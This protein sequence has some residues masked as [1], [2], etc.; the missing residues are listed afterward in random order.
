MSTRH[1]DS[2]FEPRSVAV[3]GA[4]DRPGSV[5]A[6]VWAN[7]AGG[8]FDGPVW[9]VNPR[10]PKLGTH[11]VYARASQLPEAPDL[12]VIC[13]PPA[14]VA[15]LVAELGARGTG[16]AIVM[17]AALDARQRRAL[18]DAARPH[19][20]R[21]LGPNCLGL[22]NPRLKLNASFA[23]V[24]AAPGSLAFVSQSGALV[25]ALLDWAAARG[26]G[27]SLFASIGDR[28]DVDFGDMI[29]YLASD[30]HT[31]AILL[32]VEAVESARKFMSAARAAARNKPVLIV[33]AGRTPAGQR[34]A[35]SHTGALAS[36][37]LVFDAAIRRA[38]MLRVGTLQ[39]LFTAAEMLS[40]HRGPARG[41]PA[42]PHERLTVLTNGGGAGV[43]A[44]DA[45]QAAELALAEPSAAVL[46]ALTQALPAG[47]SHANPVDIVGDAPVARYVA[48]IEAL[49]TDA[50]PGTLLFIHAPTAIVPSADVARAVVPLLQRSPLQPMTCWLGGDAVREARALS[51]AAGLPTYDTPEEAVRAFAMLQTYRRNQ[52]LLLQTPPAAPAEPLWHAAQVHAPIEAALAD[53]REWLTEPE[54]KAVLAAV[55]VPVVATRAVAAEPEA[56]VAA[57]QALGFPVALKI[58]AAELQHKSDA[59]AVVL[60]LDDA[61]S[62]R[63]AAGAMLRRVQE[64]LPGL[65]VA[66]FSVQT[67]VRRPRALELIVGA[68]LDPLFGPVILFGSGGTEVEVVADRAVALPPLNR[69]LARALVERTRVAKLLAGWRDVPPADVDAV[70]DV[71]VRVSQLLADEPRIVEL[72]LNPLLADAHGVVA[73]DARIRV[74]RQAPGGSARFAIRP[75]PADLSETVAWQDRWLT[76]RPIRPEDEAQ[77][78]EFLARLDPAD[79]RMRVFYSRRS[80]EHSEL[81]RLTQID[82]EREMAFLA[83]APKPDG[84]GEETLGVVRALCDPDNVEAEFGIVVRSDL[85]GARLGERLMRKLIDYLRARGTQRLVATVLTENRRMLDLAGRLGFDYEVEQVE[86]GTRRIVLQ[87]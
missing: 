48:A 15:P 80:I 55:G 2:L 14:T 43:L 3:F 71:L 28:L 60:D 61:A 63:D 75:Y 72:D 18:Q 10:R 84:S 24:A 83:T 6:T 74:D 37:D 47:W 59:G 4:S 77:H 73:L 76:L 51:H 7:L 54:A 65:A 11:K 17:S 86:P 70:C 20:L 49:H 85:K 67:M 42:G 62:V 27:F 12:A 30:P 44:A 64:R 38:G 8:G 81:A 46:A 45:V 22:L 41:L 35:A 39:E 1:L 69:P 68:T 66:G 16:A 21:V 58:V 52:E 33:K 31:R 40:H 78:L 79:I 5:G 36:S 82:Y 13:T 56:A 34:A 50:S 87:L 32:Y 9:P 19:L 23:H 25:T 29:D 26:V 57:A 53:G